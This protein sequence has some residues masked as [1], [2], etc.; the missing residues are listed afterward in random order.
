MEVKCEKLSDE[1]CGDLSN[2]VA[3]VTRFENMSMRN[4]GIERENVVAMENA[5]KMIVMET[6]FK[7]LGIFVNSE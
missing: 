6:V 1:D 4:V 2:L 3:F 7:R 5:M